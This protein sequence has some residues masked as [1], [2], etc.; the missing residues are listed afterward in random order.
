MNEQC[1][2]GHPIEGHQIN[3][4]DLD[5]YFVMTYGWGDGGSSQWIV[6]DEDGSDM[7]RC[8]LDEAWGYLF[9]A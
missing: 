3:I 6:K 7:L 8:S 1:N 5:G 4:T 2:E 9:E